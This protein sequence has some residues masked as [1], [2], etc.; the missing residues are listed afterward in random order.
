MGKN[1]Q[2]TTLDR[3]IAKL[4]RDLGL[5][6]I[7][8]TDV[9]EWSGEALEG[10]GT[11]T[12]YEEAVAFI[13]VKNHQAILPNGLHSIIQLARNNQWVK[14][15]TG[16]CPKDIITPCPID[17]EVPT[18]VPTDDC[19][20]PVVLDCH[21][22]PITDYELA[23]YRPYFDL[24][25]E[26]NGWNG[27]SNNVEHFSPIRLANH[28]FF[29]TIVCPEDKQVYTGSCIDEYTIQGDVLKFSF[30]EGQVALAYHRQKVD[31]ETGYPMVPDDYSVITA[32]TMYITMKYMGRLYYNG[33]E[34]YA[35]KFQKAES[36]WQWYC[37]QASNNSMIP[38][39]LDQYQNLLEGRHRM[40]PNHNSYYGFFGKMGR[41][42]STR[43]KDSDGKNLRA[44][45]R[46]I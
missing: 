2:Y 8:E 12:L 6:E 25:Y 3:V 4:Y 27:H 7:S 32:I 23:Y 36:D 1:Y 26:Y 5:D 42:D 44:Q 29:Q 11:V 20:S 46:G 10:I 18:E 33:R 14:G 37:K 30:Q 9:I 45:L 19:L 15:V 41:K 22:T 16:V 21:G 35:D 31:P 24:Q 13:E 17:I 40:I 43:W 34:G 28:T 39:G 38:H